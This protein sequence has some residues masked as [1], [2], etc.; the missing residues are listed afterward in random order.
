MIFL[1]GVKCQRV[2]AVVRDILTGLG[3][4]QLEEADLVAVRLVGERESSFRDLG[5]PELP[6]GRLHGH[7]GGLN[8]L[9]LNTGG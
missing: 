3:R 8:W 2:R 7:L 4:Q 6:L 9:G 1:G 5:E